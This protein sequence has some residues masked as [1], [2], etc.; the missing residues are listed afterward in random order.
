MGL[1]RKTKKGRLSM[2]S[3]QV[4][5]D[6][7]RE[8]RLHN[9]SIRYKA[10]RLKR[11]IDQAVITEENGAAS[12][13]QK[14]HGDR[15]DD[16]IISRNQIHHEYHLNTGRDRSQTLGSE[17]Y[18]QGNKTNNVQILMGIAIETNHLGHCTRI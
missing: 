18:L 13:K 1:G 5:T 17:E 16:M 14:K 7:Q 8:I 6:E 2:K 11:T 15:R 10:R 3:R 4:E 12:N 9:D